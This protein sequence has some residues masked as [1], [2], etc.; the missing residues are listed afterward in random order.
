MRDNAVMKSGCYSI[1]RIE[2][3]EGGQ[4]QQERPFGHKQKRQQILDLK[5]RSNAGSIQ[6]RRGQQQPAANAFHLN[7]PPPP[8]S[9]FSSQSSFF[10]G[11]PPSPPIEIPAV[12]RALF[13][14]G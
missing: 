7:V 9:M 10:A 1:R 8:A 11:K 6:K 14:E 3:N 12:V 5:G 4:S 2:A 13:R